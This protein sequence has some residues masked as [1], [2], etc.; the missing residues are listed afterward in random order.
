MPETQTQA[1]TLNLPNLSH[2][3]S[4][5]LCNQILPKFGLPLRRRS[6]FPYTAKL[7]VIPLGTISKPKPKFNH[8]FKYS[9]STIT[10]IDSLLK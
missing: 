3:L 8:Q 10:E 9:N 1:Q 6:G 7:S 2:I 4:H 5:P